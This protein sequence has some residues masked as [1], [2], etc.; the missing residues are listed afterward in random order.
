LHTRPESGAPTRPLAAQL[1]RATGKIPFAAAIRAAQLGYTFA[2][3]GY[4]GTNSIGA[5]LCGRS[6]RCRTVD[7]FSS[8][9]NQAQTR[10]PA[11]RK[12]VCCPYALK[13]QS[14]RPFAPQAAARPIGRKG[15]PLCGANA[16]AK[17]KLNYSVFGA[18]VSVLGRKKTKVFH[19][20]P[21]V[22]F[23]GNLT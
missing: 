9:P 8:T 22:F 19:T 20:S 16:P 1:G 17:E 13:G 5:T 21:F 11:R 10:N 6:R 4:G 2:A 7:Q 14:R 18:K 23:R 12:T 3:G 15:L